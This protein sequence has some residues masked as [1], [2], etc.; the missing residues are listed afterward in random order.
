VAGDF[1]MLDNSVIELGEPV[2]LTRVLY[3][4]RRI[5]ANEIILPDVLMNKDATLEM[6]QRDLDHLDFLMQH[7]DFAHY[8]PRVQAV[9]QGATIGEWFDCL[10]RMLHHVV[11]GRIHTIGVPRCTNDLADGTRSQILSQLHGQF[12]G[13]PPFEVHLLGLSDN[14]TELLEYEAYNWIRGVDSKLPIRCG[15]NWIGLH[16]EKGLMLTSKAGLPTMGLHEEEDDQPALCYH[17]IEVMKQMA[18][19]TKGQVIQWAWDQ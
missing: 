3:A 4:G 13:E 15:I 18:H 14:V 1:V 9:P 10:D 7:S 16:P 17:N 11:Q 5:H 2:E 6:L 8:K 12:G 19:D